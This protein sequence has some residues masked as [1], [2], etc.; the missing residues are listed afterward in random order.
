[1]YL[2]AD[3][4][5]FVFA[6]VLVGLWLT[7]QHKQQLGAFLAVVS[8]SSALGVAQIIIRLFP[9][10]LFLPAHLLVNASQDPSFPSDHATFAFAI[11][12]VYVGDHY[13]TDIVG[14]AALGIITSAIVWYVSQLDFCERLLKNLFSLLAQWRVA[15]KIEDAA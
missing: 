15:A 4:L 2:C 6:L 9:L 7:W 1:M 8:A 10:G 13:P 11:A 3:G 14:G 5:P 12:R